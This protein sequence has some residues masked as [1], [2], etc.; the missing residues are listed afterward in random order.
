MC[1]RLEFRLKLLARPAR[2]R[3]IAAT[4]NRDLFLSEIKIFEYT[5]V[6]VKKELESW[7]FPGELVNLPPRLTCDRTVRSDEYSHAHG[8][9]A[10]TG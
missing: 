6:P 9:T 8:C 2:T 10:K 5:I 1:K 4:E 3:R 7:P